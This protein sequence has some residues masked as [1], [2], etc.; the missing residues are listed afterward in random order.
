MLGISIYGYRKIKK[1]ITYSTRVKDIKLKHTV[2]L[3]KIDLKYLNR[4]HKYISVTNIYYMCIDR[5]ISIDTFAK[6]Y[7]N[8]P[9]HYKFNLMILEKSAKGFWIGKNIKI[10]NNFINKH[11]SYMITRL[12]SVYK[13]VANIV[14]CS[15]MYED[16][17]NDTF[18][19]LYEKCGSIVLEFYFDMKVLFNILMCKAKYIMLNIYR[20]NYSNQNVSCDSF[21]DISVDH[22]RFLQD[23]T[24]NPEFMI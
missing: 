13:K 7:S 23:N 5:N 21:K 2:D 16:L 22:I 18:D 3:I 24:Y 9:K 4:K 8:N 11:H 1:D 17:I 19:E 10:P 20:K 12:K 15:Y 14:N 6:Y